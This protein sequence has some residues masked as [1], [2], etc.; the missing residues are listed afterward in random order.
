MKKIRRVK[1]DEFDIQSAPLTE[2]ER[3]LISKF[4]SESK[5]RAKKKPISKLRNAKTKV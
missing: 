1:L 2:E 4:I 5:K 3:V